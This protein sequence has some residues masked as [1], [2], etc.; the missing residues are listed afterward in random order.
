M[1]KLFVALAIVATAAQAQ[2][3]SFEVKKQQVCST[4]GRNWQDV[5]DTGKLRGISK[6]Y[7]K[8]M[9]TKG[10][11][12][13]GTYNFV[14]DNFKNVPERDHFPTSHDAYMAGWAACMD[15]LSGR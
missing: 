13:E 7:Y 3:Y 14:M 12:S 1:K 11:L 10:K 8:E 4:Q 6:E 5:N 15:E 2:T 9:F